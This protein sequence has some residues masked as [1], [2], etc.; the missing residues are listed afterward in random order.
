LKDEAASAAKIHEKF[1]VIQLKGF[2][3]NIANSQISRL[4]VV[5]QL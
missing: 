3:V 1:C 5:D 2:Q 4:A